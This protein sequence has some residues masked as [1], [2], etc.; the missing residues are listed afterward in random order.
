M[1]QPSS[2][3]SRRLRVRLG[4]FVGIAVVIAAF[5]VRDVALGVLSWWL[6]LLALLI[7]IVLGYAL[8]RLWNVKVHPDS[9]EV[10]S[11]IDAVGGIAIALYVAF[12]LSR[13]WIFGHWIHGPA[14]SAFTL[15]ILSGALFGRF[16]GMRR[17]IRRLLA[18]S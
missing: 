10:V 17:S 6:A 18:D 4:I 1:A 9:Q 8:G 5:I 3:V 11:G 7:G 13:E 15:A 14:L 12:D 2:R 16:L